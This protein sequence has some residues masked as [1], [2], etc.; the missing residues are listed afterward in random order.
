MEKNTP[1]ERTYIDLARKPEWF[2]AIS[3]LGKTPV[4]LVDEKD[5]LFESAVI[6]EYLEETQP[7]QRLHPSDPLTR[8][9]HR[10]WMEFASAT[11]NDIWAY[12]VAPD[13]AAFA[14]KEKALADKFA[15]LEG[16][17]DATGPYFSGPRFSLV[18]AAFGPVFR[19]FDVFEK[20]FR[21]EIFA[22]KPKVAAWRT[23]LAERDS[24]R[25]A[26]AEDYPHRLAEF[27]I[28]RNSYMS[29]LVR[30]SAA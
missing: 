22:H 7:G 17:L 16:V 10:A 12:Y 19:Y 27:L 23:A 28:N 30:V 14:L 11:L 25:M 21:H 9:R 29:G 15:T 3:P 8:A 6:C 13:E 4:M 20:Y 26:V 24:I 5:A 2:L 18:D 1:H